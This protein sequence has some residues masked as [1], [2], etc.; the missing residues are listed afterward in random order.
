LPEFGKN[1]KKDITVFQLLTHQGGLI[2][3]NPIAH[4]KGG[5]QKAWK[6]IC[7]LKPVSAPG[8]KFAYTDV[9][10]IVLGKL[11]K[12]VSGMDLDTFSRKNIFHPLNMLKTGFLPEPSLREK[13]AVTIKRKKKWIKGEVHDPRAFK[14]GG[15]AGHAGLFST[16]EDLA[17]FCQMM[18]GKGQYRGI[19]ILKAKTAAVMIKGY[20][21]SEGFRGLGWDVLTDYSGNRGDTFSPRA[22]GHGGF[23]GT[24]LWIDPELD[25]FVIF[26]S[27]RVHINQKE[28]VNAIA[29]D[30][31]KI[32][33]D[34]INDPDEVSVLTGIDV[35]E[36]DG[37]RQL[38]GRR[39]GL[40]TNHTGVNRHGMASSKLLHDAT[41]VTIVALFSP[42]H[43]PNG[44]LD[45]GD[46]RNSHHESLGI[47]V[48]SLYGKNRKPT[49]KMLRGI[50]TLI[51]D[52]QDIGT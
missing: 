35:L 1:G 22:F 31:G 18:M 21:V 43:G 36:R 20:P 42:E 7:N 34:A 48:Y 3:D 15:I 19:R 40:I 45:I 44:D 41:N 4:Y 37:F 14:L 30:I 25:L 10:F 13:A 8:E 50:D 12:R 32:A 52:I 38:E 9:G 29:G 5:P 24:S 23:T 26:L 28:S 39:V 11:V 17:I 51:F 6:N 49:E 16:A 46:I 33:A 2:P 47:P 27:N